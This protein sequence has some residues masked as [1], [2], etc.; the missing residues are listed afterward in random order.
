MQLTEM[1]K[2]GEEIHQEE[3]G[4]CLS[5]VGRSQRLDEGKADYLLRGKR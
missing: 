4:E 2:E 1:R 3:E 5:V